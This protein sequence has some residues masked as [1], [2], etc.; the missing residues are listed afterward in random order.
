MTNAMRALVGSSR[1]RPRSAIFATLSVV[2]GVSAACARQSA[3][4]AS[5][6]AQNMPSAPL[7]R[8]S[9]LAAPMA[10]SVPSARE[11]PEAPEVPEAPQPPETADDL[12]ARLPAD[13]Q[14]KRPL[15]ERICAPA[16]GKYTG[17]FVSELDGVLVFG[18]SC[19]A[20]FEACLPTG[21]AELVVAEPGSV[22]PLRHSHSGSFTK[23][24]ARELAATFMGCEPGAADRGGTMI[25]REVGMRLG[26]VAYRSGVNPDACKVLTRRGERDR[27][28]CL[29][30]DGMGST[31][32]TQLLLVDLAPEANNLTEIARFDSD[33]ACLFGAPEPYL[34]VQA[35]NFELVDVNRDR[36]LDVVVDATAQSGVL[37][38]ADLAACTDDALL[39]TTLP[40][41]APERFVYL[42]RGD[43]FVA[44]GATAK[45]LDALYRVRNAHRGASSGP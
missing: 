2:S 42:A 11:L 31:N 43:G 16:I 28:V 8:E 29:R 41:P 15:I 14:A 19:C 25:F 36:R 45:R 27:L 12:F 34:S 9:A 37:S 40:P 4:V 35:R 44:E 21:D 6:P 20:P 22:Y 17:E 24:G 39:P 18:C 3:S 32:Y 23:A 38:E 1:W 13:E 30:S 5:G 26:Q 10:S 7:P 33:G